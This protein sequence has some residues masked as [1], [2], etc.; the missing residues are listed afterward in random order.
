MHV[1]HNEVGADSLREFGCDGVRRGK[2]CV[3]VR[4]PV[5]VAAPKV[6]HRTRQSV[7][8]AQLS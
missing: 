4:S 6:L 1:T 5:G 3:P 7:G 8:H 2:G